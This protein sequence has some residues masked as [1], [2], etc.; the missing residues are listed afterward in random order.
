[1]FPNARPVE[2]LVFLT[3]SVGTGNYVE[4]AHSGSV[5]AVRDSKDRV[6]RQFSLGRRRFAALA[7]ITRFGLGL[8]WRLT[9]KLWFGDRAYW[10]NQAEM[11]AF[12][13]GLRRTRPVVPVAVA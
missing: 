9:R 2:D 4:W 1:M 7:A 8:N 3:A 13:G 5:V 10:F 6:N 12:I 11:E